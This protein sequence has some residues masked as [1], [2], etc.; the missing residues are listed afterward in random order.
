MAATGFTPIQ[1]YYSTTTSSVP[2]AANLSPGELALNIADMKLYCENSSGVVTL[3]ASAAGATG[4][5][6]GPASATDNAIVRFDGTTGKLVQDSAV[7]IADDGDVVVSVNSTGDA[8]RI[9]Q[10][11][12]GN[13]LVVEDSANPDSTPFVVNASGQ[14]GIGTTS[15]TEML[16]VENTTTNA[17]FVLRSDVGTAINHQRSTNDGDTP[18]YNFIKTRGTIAS[19]LAVQT[20]D[21]LGQVLFV[22]YGG[23]NNRTLSGIRSV[24]ENYTSDTNISSALVFSNANAGT[25]PSEVMRITAAGNVGVG[26]SG[27]AAKLEA[28]GAIQARP[29][30]TQDAVAI[31]GRAGGTS[32]YVVTLTP[33]TLSASRTLTL[34]DPGSDETLGYLNIP[35]NS[36]SAAYTLVLTDAGKHILHPSADT[37]ARTFTIPANGSVAFPIGTAVTFIN[38]NGAGVVTISITTDTM[39]LAG[40]G[41]TGSRTLAANGIAT[42]IKI[43]STEWIISGTGLT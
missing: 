13:A 15:P 8:L 9:T 43:T 10:T 38:Q 18:N 28:Y 27:P 11:G 24:I 36:Q 37:T 29:A 5:V 33:A 21:S 1:L 25:S 39:R 34:P 42:A 19:P 7:T 3:L 22:G 12:T 6:V 40:A 23:T 26:T 41:T 32:S 20:G 35:Q 2:L 30:A 16:V 14:V 31:A 4:D 17:R